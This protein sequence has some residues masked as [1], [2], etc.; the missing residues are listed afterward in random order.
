MIYQFT[1][2]EKMLLK[3]GLIPQPLFDTDTVLCLGRALAAAV[4]SG[5]TTYLSDQFQAADEL[6]SKSGLD[7]NMVPLVL[8]CMKALGYLEK[9]ENTY[10]F[11]KT[12]KRF[13]DKDSPN[14][15]IHY[16]LFSNQIH[17]R[18]FLHLDEMLESGRVH[19]DNLN[20]FTAEEWKLFTLAMQDI[21]RLSIDE[22]IRAI[23]APS[24]KSKL[25]DVGGS[26][27]LYS[28]YQCKKNPLLKA[29]ILDLEP[30][31]PYLEENVARYK[32]SN[33][34]SLRVGDFMET[35]WG[36]D[37]DLVFAF[38][39]IHGMNEEDNQ[40]FFT[41][42]F[43]ALKKGGSFIIFDQVKGLNGKSQLSKA[44]PAYL[45]LNL[46]IQTGGRTY[47]EQ[48]LVSM[49]KK[50]SFK[51]VKLKKLRTPGTALLIAGK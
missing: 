35:E 15:L 1:S 6:A 19:R 51:K 7:K 48:E 40:K 23:P 12:G 26:H 30:V 38:N 2:L 24:G 28:I 16:I 36:K 49:L 18:S 11:S 37:Y 45:G 50:A 8:D 32:M 22:I 34:V 10:A 25:L 4:S 31:R 47:A 33:Q 3:K 21:A 14:N 13:L 39:I 5:L 29:E 41:K 42:A 9:K 44:V 27:G 20:N 17:F 43:H 46:Y